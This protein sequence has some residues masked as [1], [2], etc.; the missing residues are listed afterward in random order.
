MTR[1]LKKRHFYT[2]RKI[3]WNKFLSLGEISLVESLARL[4]ATFGDP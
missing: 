3:N 1:L 4:L 2:N